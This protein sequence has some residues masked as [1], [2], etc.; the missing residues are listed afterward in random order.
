MSNPNVILII[1]ESKTFTF[2]S[3]LFNQL[4]SFMFKSKNHFSLCGGIIP[5]MNLFFTGQI[6]NNVKI[7]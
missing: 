2:D 5:A 6:N 1:S 3:N 7:Y 4:T